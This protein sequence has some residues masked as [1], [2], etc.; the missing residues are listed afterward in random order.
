MLELKCSEGNMVRYEYTIEHGSTKL[1]IS[2][3][4]V[5][6]NLN[7]VG[8]FIFVKAFNSDPKRLVF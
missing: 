6:K 3:L 5:A 2:G 4:K 7:R 1:Q 8:K